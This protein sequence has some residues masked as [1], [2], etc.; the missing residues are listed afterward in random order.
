MT[1]NLEKIKLPPAK[2][3]TEDKKK[4]ISENAKVNVPEEFKQK[5][6]DLLMKHHEVISDSKYVQL[7][8]TTMS[9]ALKAQSTSNSSEFRRPNKRQY[10]NMWKSN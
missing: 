6:M 10:K 1:A 4:Y 5:Y 3:L 9:Y 2:K 8:C 7:Q